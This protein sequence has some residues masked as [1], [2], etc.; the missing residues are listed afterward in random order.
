[1]SR[2]RV[3]RRASGEETMAEIRECEKFLECLSAHFDGELDEELLVEF[4]QHLRFCS[5]ARA[6]VSTFERTIILHRQA[7]PDRVPRGVHKRLLE[8]IE[9]CRD[10]DE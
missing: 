3:L 2:P 7:R 6:V 9:K 4:E 10:C 5:N 1:M 8:A